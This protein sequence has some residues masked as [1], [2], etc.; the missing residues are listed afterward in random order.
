MQ[1][2]NLKRRIRVG[3]AIYLTSASYP[4]LTH[5]RAPDK[6]KFLRPIFSYSLIFLQITYFMG[7]YRAVGK[8]EYFMIIMGILR[9]NML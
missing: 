2:R 9:D 1:K 3:A 6:S 4:Q 5:S 7:S 8:T